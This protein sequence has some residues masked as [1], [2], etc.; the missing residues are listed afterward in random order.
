MF[1]ASYFIYTQKKKP[2]MRV[3]YTALFIFCTAFVFGQLHQ[4]TFLENP[5]V[6]NRVHIDRPESLTR[7]VT[8]CDTNDLLDFSSYTEIYT[9]LQGDSASSLYGFNG[10]SANLLYIQRLTTFVTLAN[11]DS[12]FATYAGMAFDTLP[13]PGLSQSTAFQLPHGFLNDY[14]EWP[15]L[16][17]PIYR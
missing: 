8:N 10:A 2:A 11:A 6:I 1:G 14:T 4:Q 13:F 17:L 9:L 12:G 7:S 15:A 3:L 16:Y 5:R